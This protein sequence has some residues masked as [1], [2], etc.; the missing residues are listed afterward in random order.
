[1]G[2]KPVTHHASG[3]VGRRG[4]KN[5]RFPAFAESLPLQG[6]PVHFSLHKVS[7]PLPLYL[8]ALEDVVPHAGAA[9][10]NVEVG[11]GPSLAHK[12]VVLDLR[13]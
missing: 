12:A 8:F 4:N 9:K 3:R 5:R 1:M 11:V 10:V 2:K 7:L 6:I 13:R